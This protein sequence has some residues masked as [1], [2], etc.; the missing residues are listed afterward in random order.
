[1]RLDQLLKYSGL[2]P[3]RHIA[4][5]FCSHNAVKVNG[6]AKKPTA[7]VKDMDIVSVNIGDKVI[8]FYFHEE[9]EDNIIKIGFEL[10]EDKSDA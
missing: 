2:F 1:M 5:F 7:Q 9:K 4:K 3:K 8:E 6:V 10:I